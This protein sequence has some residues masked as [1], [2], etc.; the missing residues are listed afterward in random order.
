MAQGQLT[1]WSAMAKM[2]VWSSDLLFLPLVKMAV[3]IWSPIAKMVVRSSD[4]PLAKMVPAHVL[5]D[6]KRQRV[7]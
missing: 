4:L 7:S 1:T 3:V 6:T 5:Q 2:Q